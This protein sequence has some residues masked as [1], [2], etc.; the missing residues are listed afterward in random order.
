MSSSTPRGKSFERMKT[1][2]VHSQQHSS[3]ASET[4]DSDDDNL[5]LAHK[6][7][8]AS[9]TR[10]A[11]TRA[12]QQSR[13]RGKVQKSRLEPNNNPPGSKFLRPL[14]SIH[15]G[16]TTDKNNKKNKSNSKKRD[17]AKGLDCMR[18]NPTR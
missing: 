8:I 1:L 17:N 13:L 12:V 16:G 4:D 18:N 11:T 2:H 9:I 14:P 15:K 5:P 7:R 10:T 3:S 6:G